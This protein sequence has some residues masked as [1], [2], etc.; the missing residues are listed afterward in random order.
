MIRAICDKCGKESNRADGVER[1]YLY[2][3]EFDLCEECYEI[4]E[5]VE[6]EMSEMAQKER[7]LCE[8]EIRKKAMKM[9]GEFEKKVKKGRKKDEKESI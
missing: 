8:R 3:D 6:T 5:K 2:D 9:M 7:A 4:Y 1:V